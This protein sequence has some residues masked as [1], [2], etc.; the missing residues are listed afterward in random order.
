MMRLEHFETVW[1]ESLYSVKPYFS[2]KNLKHFFSISKNKNQIL[3]Q[4][5]NQK[6]VLS[7]FKA[8]DRIGQDPKNGSLDRIQNK[9]PN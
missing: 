6:S 4:I 8:S 5:K 1:L 3:N 2:R 9:Q 7:G